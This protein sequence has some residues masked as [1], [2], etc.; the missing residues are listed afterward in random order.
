MTKI[1]FN[2]EVRNELNAVET[3]LDA[4]IVFLMGAIKAAQNAS[5]TV[6]EKILSDVQQHTKTTAE[7]LR[8]LF[9]ADNN[10]DDHSVFDMPNAERR[11]MI[12]RHNLLDAAE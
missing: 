9:A 5:P 6:R 3:E 8:F 1:R 11:R 10:N 2:S 7:E 12:I 4:D